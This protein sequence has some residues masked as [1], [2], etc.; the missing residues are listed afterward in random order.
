MTLLLILSRAVQFGSCLLLLSIFL[1]RLL[2]HQYV[3]KEE[4]SA[5]TLAG[6]CLLLA[7]VSGAG[8][9]WTAIAG[10]N[11][12]GLIESLNLTL[13]ET[14]INE[15]T[16]GRVWAIRFA[17]GVLLALLLKLSHRPWTW[18][19]GTALSATLTGSLAWLGHAGAGEGTRGTVMLALDVIHLV[20]ASVWPAGLVPFALILRRQM[21]AGVL[22]AARAAVRRF[23][24]ISLVTVGVLSG[25][26]IGT[27]CFLVGSFHA[28]MTTTY[29]RL[30]I[31]K[32]TLFLAAISLG[33]WN[34]LVHKPRMESMPQA[35][36]G[37]AQKVSVE[38]VLGMLIVA[39]VAILGMMPPA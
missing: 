22:P 4:R 17:T 9:F 37:I 28:L 14:V 18:I 2:F 8:W 13:F 32:V 6:I 29:G 25:S 20:A 30:L 3:E 31:I 26:G 33:A 27:A 39:V 7:A 34:L 10:M 11:G 5:R 23:S 1:M 15:T 38:I 12:T 36:G 35:L 16:F 24:L 21:K 19:A